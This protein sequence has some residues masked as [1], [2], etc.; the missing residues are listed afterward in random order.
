M[1]TPGRILTLLLVAKG[2]TGRTLSIDTGISESYLSLLKR[3]SRAWTPEIVDSISSRL[4]VSPETL[5]GKNTRL[6]KAIIALDN[7]IAE[8]IN[9]RL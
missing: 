4:N 7:A 8:V 9:D 3:D 6:N 2:V 5:W 1:I